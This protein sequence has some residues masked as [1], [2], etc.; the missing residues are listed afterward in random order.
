MVQQPGTTIYP[1]GD[2]QVI[3]PGESQ[4]EVGED[5][6]SLDQGWLW[7]DGGDALA[8]IIHTSAADIS[9]PSGKFAIEVLP[10]SQWLYLFDGSAEVRRRDEETG[11]PVKSDQMV[12]L[13]NSQGLQPVEYNPGVLFV[14]Q[15]ATN[16]I[17]LTWEPTLGERIITWFTRIGVG[18][19]QALTFITYAFGF[20][21][22]VIAPMAAIYS[23]WKD[24][25]TPKT[26]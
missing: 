22:L 19:A 20:L 26:N 18:S 13:S 9:I 10:Q 4:V 12:N 5:Y 2:G 25:K 7:G 23:W 8:M 14:L 16:P 15:S 21:A 3:I 6:F 17:G 1:W 24:R 11:T